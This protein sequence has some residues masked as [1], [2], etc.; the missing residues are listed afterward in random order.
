MSD[1]PKIK[2]LL[3]I[4]RDG[5]ETMFSTED[6]LYILGFRSTLEDVL[7]RAL[8]RDE[9]W[10]ENRQSEVYKESVSAPENDWEE[11]KVEHESIEANVYYWISDMG[12]IIVFR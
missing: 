5:T 2:K 3:L 9:F 10:V 12:Q 6:E 4:E 11:P 7:E 8:K 1:N